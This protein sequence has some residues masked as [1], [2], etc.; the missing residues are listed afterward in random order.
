[1]DPCFISGGACKICKR[2]L[3]PSIR[4]AWCVAPIGGLTSAGIQIGNV[5]VRS[6]LRVRV[7][8]NI[9]RGYWL[10]MK[11][12]WR[13]GFGGS[14]PVIGWC[15]LPSGAFPYPRRLAHHP[16]RPA[17]AANPKPITSPPPLTA[18]PVHSRVGVS[19]S[20]LVLPHPARRLLKLRRADRLI[21]RAFTFAQDLRQLNPTPSTCVR[22][23][24][25][26]ASRV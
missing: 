24:S 11:P 6:V 18:A 2:S 12:S 26:L 25:S 14:T 9:S 1:M 22:Q 20:P 4:A 10:A 19:E 23:P 16:A 15:W 8:F 5:R 21:E 17:S 7:A 13:L 3:R